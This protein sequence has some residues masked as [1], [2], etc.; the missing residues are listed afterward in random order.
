VGDSFFTDTYG[1][2]LLVIYLQ[3]SVS[4]T[5]ANLS[6]PSHL[7]DIFAMVPQNVQRSPSTFSGKDARL[8]QYQ[9]VLANLSSSNKT[10]PSSDTSADDTLQDAM[11]W[12]SDDEDAE[13]MKSFKVNKPEKSGPLLGG[14]ADIGT[15]MR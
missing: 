7:V 8:S 11:E 12:Q 4:R 6:S 5:N 14:F 15:S 3:T 1:H 2:V 13:V 9:N 10:D